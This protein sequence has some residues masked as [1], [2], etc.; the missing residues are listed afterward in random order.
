MSGVTEYNGCE[1]WKILYN[2]VLYNPETVY[3]HIGRVVSLQTRTLQYFFLQDKIMLKKEGG[4]LLT[5]CSPEILPQRYIGFAFS[6]MPMNRMKEMF[7]KLLKLQLEFIASLE[8][9]K[10]EFYSVNLENLNQDLIAWSQICDLLSEWGNF[11]IRVE[12]KENA[13]LTPKMMLLLSEVCKDTRIRIYIDDLC[14]CCHELPVN[15]EY[16]IM[17]IEILHPF[18]QAVKIDYVV[19]RDILYLEEFHQVQKNLEDFR[20]L[21]ESWCN[22]SAPLV[23]F[24][25][26]PREDRRWL[27]RLTELAYG[28]SGYKFQTG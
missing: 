21:W 6:E 26:M 22:S 13:T 23:I 24:E 4:E 2:A 8:T 18:I 16:I 7:P 12:I 11:P 19:M 17:M 27:R 1:A 28:Y 3:F 20:W 10:N 9:K 14:S 15:E 5:R 25:S